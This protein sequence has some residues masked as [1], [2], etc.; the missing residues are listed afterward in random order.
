MAYHSRQLISE[1]LELKR[2]GLSYRQ[3]AL[4]LG[5]KTSQVLGICHRENHRIRRESGATEALVRT[6][7]DA[8]DRD[9]R[10]SL[11]FIPGLKDTMKYKLSRRTG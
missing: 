11:P 10:P 8:A 7:M 4:R 1:V 5:M 6:G 2:D 3:V 9:T